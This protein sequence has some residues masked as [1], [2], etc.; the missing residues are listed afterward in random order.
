MPGAAPSHDSIEGM[1]VLC[2]N[3]ECDEWVADGSGTAH[4]NKRRM[5]YRGQR[6]DGVHVYVC[7]SCDTS[8]Y[9]RVGTNGLLQEYSPSSGSECF[10]ATVA[11]GSINAP[12]VEQFR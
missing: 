2:Q 6:Q 4:R 12:E 7:P 3:S 11:Y 8:R 9:Y 1:Q 5:Q 10:V